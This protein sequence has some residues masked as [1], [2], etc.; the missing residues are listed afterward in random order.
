LSR[1]HDDQL[2]LR[3]DPAELFVEDD[4]EVTDVIRDVSPVRGRFARLGSGQICGDI[5]HQ[6]DVRLL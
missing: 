5:D 3:L 2:D 4:F 6:I 1:R